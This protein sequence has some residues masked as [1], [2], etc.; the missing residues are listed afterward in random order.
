M[1][2][3]CSITSKIMHKYQVHLVMVIELQVLKLQNLSITDDYCNSTIFD[4]T[5]NLHA[6]GTS[7]VLVKALHIPEYGMS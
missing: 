4:R 6:D 5:C 3:L 1:N 2:F 7:N